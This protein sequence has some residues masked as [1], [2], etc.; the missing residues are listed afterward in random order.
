MQLSEIQ[1]HITTW[2][3]APT[4][5]A[6]LL[7]AGENVSVVE[8]FIASLPEALAVEFHQ[9][10]GKEESIRVHQIRELIHV[11]SRTSHTGKRLVLIAQADTLLPASGNA[12]LKSLEEAS[13]DNRFLLT[14]SH[15][16]RLLPTIRS[17]CSL[18]YIQ[19]Q[20]QDIETVK[21]PVFDTKRKSPLS[22]EEARSI[23]QYLEQHIARETPSQ[24]LVRSLQRLRDYYKVQALGGNVRMAGDVL[25]ASM[26]ELEN[27]TT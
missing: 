9:L 13:S 15:I 3:Q 18:I 17:R 23:A 1:K 27:T 24:E 16:G 5:Q 20:L 6:P 19:S 8:L 12:L 11:I 21:V 25:L 2:V 10:S 7:I 14:T 4:P 26:A 22:K